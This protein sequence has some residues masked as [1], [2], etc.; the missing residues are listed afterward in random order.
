MSQ[1]YL[2]ANIKKASF[3]QLLYKYDYMA[4]QPVI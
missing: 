1:C 2:V 3:V 4:V